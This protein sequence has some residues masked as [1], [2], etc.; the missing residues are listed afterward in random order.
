MFILRIPD[1]SA[2]EKH[3]RFMEWLKNDI[4]I[5]VHKSGCVAF[6]ES[7]KLS[8]SVYNAIQGSKPRDGPQYSYAL[9]NSAAFSMPTRKRNLQKGKQSRASEPCRSNRRNDSWFI[10]RKKPVELGNIHFLKLIKIK[11]TTTCKKK[12]L[13]WKLR[14]SFRKCIKYFQRTSYSFSRQGKPVGLWFESCQAGRVSFRYPIGMM[15]LK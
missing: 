9:V 4:G 2:G 15:N 12:S 10:C 8:L 1:A 7:T 5:E 13:S 11:L 3:N 14:M 6:S